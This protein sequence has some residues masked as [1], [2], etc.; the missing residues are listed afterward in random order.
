M[1]LGLSAEG[2]RHLSVQTAP[3]PYSACAATGI[4][5]LPTQPSCEELPHARSVSPIPAVN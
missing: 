1:Q 4:T 2:T 5:V 3:D